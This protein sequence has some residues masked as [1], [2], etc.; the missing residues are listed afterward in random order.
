MSKLNLCRPVRVHCA[1]A[2]RRSDA[3]ASKPALSCHWVFAAVFGLVSCLTLQKS[4]YAK[5]TMLDPVSTQVVAGGIHSCALT[6]AGRVL[7]WGGGDHGQLGTSLV[8]QSSVPVAVESLTNVVSIASG[9][10]HTCALTTLGKVWCWGYNSDGALGD[11]SFTER[12]TPVAVANLDNVVAITAGEDHT[13]ALTAVGAVYCWGNNNHSQLGDGTTTKESTPVVVKNLTKGVIAIS[14]SGG[15]HTCA[16]TAAGSALC[17]GWNAAGQLG[18]GTNADRSTPVQV[19]GLSSGIVAIAAGGKHT[20]AL[21]TIKSIHCWGFNNHGQLGDGTGIDSWTPV[22]VKNLSNVV[23]LTSGGSV[24]SGS[25]E[26]YSCAVTQDGSTYCWGD[27]ILGQLGDGSFVD[28]WVP[29]RVN[30][31]FALVGAGVEHTCALTAIGG[32]YCWGLNALGDLGDGTKTS[33]PAPVGVYGLSSQISALAAGYAHTCAL[34]AD[35]VRCWGANNVGQLGDGTTT[36][37]GVP[38]AVPGLANVSAIAAGFGHTCA[39]TTGGSVSCWG[40][41]DLGQLGDGTQTERW[42]P[43]AVNGLPAG[44]VRITAG[45]SHNCALTLAGAVWCWGYNAN[46]EVG[47]GSTGNNRLLP[48]PVSGL[49]AGGVIV[50]SVVAG[51]QHTCALTA[52]GD[53]ACWGYNSHGQLGDGTNTSRS[54]PTVVGGL[55][56]PVATIAAGYLHT[57]VQ[58]TSGALMCWGATIWG[59]VGD[60]TTS[61]DRLK[62]TCPL[63]LCA[64]GAIDGLWGGSINDHTWARVRNQA[65]IW[66]WGNNF[67]G[68]LGLGDSGMGTNRAQ[69]VKNP[70]FNGLAPRFTMTAGGDH[71]CALDDTG[72]RCMGYNSYGQLGDG[73]TTQQNSPVPVLGGQSVAFSVPASLTVGST[74]ALAA[75]ADSG[76]PVTFDSWTPS[77]CTVSGNILKILAA[78]LCGVRASQVGGTLATGGSAAAAPQQLRLIQ[79]LAATTTTLTS[80]V[81]PSA[82]GQ[83]VTFTATVTG[84]SPTGTVTFSDGTTILCNAVALT[85]TGNSPT[86]TCTTA[87]LAVGTHPITAV[88]SGDTANAASTSLVLSQVVQAAAGTL[89]LASSLNP[90]TVGQSVTFTATIAGNAPTGTVTFY[91]GLSIICPAPVVLTGT[92]NTRTA[93]CVTAALTVGTH[94]LTAAYSGDANNAATTSAALVQI[95][96]SA[97]LTPT[98]TTLNLSPNPATV[99]QS[100]TATVTVRPTS[101][102]GLPTGSVTVSGGVTSCTMTLS[103]GT[104]SCTLVFATA[105]ARTVTAN[106]G[107]SGSYVASSAAATVT[108][109]ASTNGSLVGAPMLDA[110]SLGLLALGLLALAWRGHLRRP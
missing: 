82:P 102:T 107:G 54:V 68:Q 77:T 15:D 63:T 50:G 12:H 28:R 60:G 13:C 64:V 22:D 101:G 36:S 37:R 42:S 74:F 46:G 52:A 19:N 14:A 90:S 57:C 59:Q 41:N 91:E 33:R 85:G 31:D 100:V 43:A 97:G 110:R 34:V 80:S 109:T 49:G 26:G 3:R 104:G 72:L 18:D 35:T 92:G 39:L 32:V 48:V 5:G 88:Y 10:A 21:T 93:S 61:M 79:A 62:P 8:L 96:Q 67:F 103:A 6:T 69:P 51:G 20:C 71:T 65:A 30:G 45:G 95:V 16:V 86:A 56:G 2:L 78:S 11:G 29:T 4:A 55:P 87:T 58:T 105:G 38:L 1:A 98:T 70:A 7:C 53:V 73:S 106:Y 44:I 47:D 27:N 94:N 9:Y 75:S 17:W 40:N 99:G 84:T 89:A 25:S 24:T 76:L 66:G 83:S 108:V 81:N 23:S